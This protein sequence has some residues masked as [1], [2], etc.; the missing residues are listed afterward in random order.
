MGN[1]LSIIREPAGADYFIGYV[2]NLARDLRV[3]VH[4]TYVEEEYEYTIGRPPA[5]ANYAGDEQSKKLSEA[6]KIL[7]ERVEAVV[8]GIRNEISLDF[9]AELTTLPSVID[10]YIHRNH[11]DMIILEAEEP[12]G[13]MFTST[14]NAELIDEIASPVLLVPRDITFRPLR[15]IV[16]ATTYS[17][18]DIRALNDL[19]RIT[20]SVKP[21]IRLVHIGDDPDNSGD[22]MGSLGFAN[23]VRKETGYSDI[24]LDRLHGS[25]GES[26]PGQIMDYAVRTNADLVVVLKDERNFFERLFAPDKTKKIAKNPELPVLIYK[27]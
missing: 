20:S 18:N 6:R 17:E 21:S 14:S 10:D 22:L 27:S 19:M 23:M 4:I 13:L 8:G 24:S 26:I 3:H 12:R 5:P 9:S 2:A 1:L 15:Q 11:P 7:S 16:Y 25:S